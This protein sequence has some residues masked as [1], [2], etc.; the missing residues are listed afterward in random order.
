MSSSISNTTKVQQEFM[1]NITQ[2]NQA[3]CLATVNDQANG[4][5]VIISGSTIAGDATGVSVTTSTDATCLMV[6]NMQDSVDNILASITDQTN[7]AET[8][9]FNG[10]QFTNESNSYDLKQTIANNISQIN[11]TTCAANNSTS[12]S[13][14]YVYVSSSKVG[15]NFVG[16]TN[17]ASA[18]ANCSMNNTMANATYNKAQSQNSQSNTVKGVFATLVGLFSGIMGILIIGAVLLFALEAAGKAKG[19][20]PRGSSQATQYGTSAQVVR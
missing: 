18:A 9:F 6:S 2:S 8:D 3:N 5:V 12:T 17:T 7:T 10:F 4:N 15:G 11:Q 14:N 13:N 16:V 19:S 1:N 20:I